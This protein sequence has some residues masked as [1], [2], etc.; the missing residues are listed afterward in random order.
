MRTP[1]RPLTTSSRALRMGGAAA[2]AAALTLPMLGASEADAAPA[3]PG[4]TGAQGCSERLFTGLT[5][6]K[7]AARTNPDAFGKAAARNGKSRAHFNRLAAD[8]D[9]RLDSCGQALYVEEVHTAPAGTTAGAATASAAAAAPTPDQA[10]TLE[11]KPG[12]NRTLFL[13]FDGDTTSGSAW[14]STANG[15]SFTSPAYDSDGAPGTF[16]TAERTEIV[17]AWQAVAEDYAPFDVNVTTKDPGLAAIDRTSSSDLVYG[18]RV[19][20]TPSNP[21]FVNDCGSGCGGIAYV[22]VFNSSGTNHLYYQP[23]FVFTGGVGNGGKNIAEAASHEAGHNFGLNHDGTSTQG[24]YAGASGWAPIMGVGYYEPLSQWSNGQ[25]PDANEPQDDL[26][27]IATGAPVRADDFGPDAATAGTLTTAAPL[28]GLITT[29]ADV[30]AFRFS[31]AGTTTVT[32]SVAAAFANL[33]LSLTVRDQAGAVVAT[34]DPAF[35]KTSSSVATGLGASVTFTAPDAGATYTASVDGVANAASRTDYGSLGAYSIAL[36]TQV[37]SGPAPLAASATAL[38]TGTVGT[39]Y[40][41]VGT[42]SIS[43]GVAPYA[44]TAASLP[45]GLSLS[46]AGQL[47]G[48]PTAAGTSALA[49]TVTD[50]AGASVQVAS[51][52]TVNPAATPFAFTTASTLPSA[53][54]RT[55]YA[56]TIAISGGSPAFT[57]SRVSGSYPNGTSMQ[58]AAD[59]RSVR[60]SGTPTRTGTYSFTLRVR[61]AAGATVSRSFS[62]AVTR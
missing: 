43:G 27:V 36:Q 37:V 18:T 10:F 20:V 31:A 21:V 60:L 2:L 8:D 40:G 19:V 7:T 13:D 16:S 55:S 47:S 12:S 58:L 29:A 46:S 50:A 33:D 28:D 48:T 62:V 11:S 14:N 61:D 59:G 57:W 42:V 39:A 23:A 49:L 26:A 17:R 24:Y 32:A 5:K 51:S 54:L 44:V 34:A 4:G 35:A 30:D 41:P 53:R 45:A 25:Y 1:R 9:M 52:V 38:P 3:R 22:G 6:A 15:A 56:T